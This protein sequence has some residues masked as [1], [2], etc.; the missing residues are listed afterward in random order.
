MEVTEHNLTNW[1]LDK[2]DIEEL[3]CMT[4]REMNKNPTDRI[5]QTYYGILLGKLLIM[6]NDKN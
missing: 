6:K 1:E 4:R 2:Y 5:H 3:I